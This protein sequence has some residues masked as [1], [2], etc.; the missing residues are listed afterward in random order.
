MTYKIDKVD[1]QRIVSSAKD[2]FFYLSPPLFVSRVEV[3]RGEL[4]SLAMLESVLMFL[5]S[6]GLLTQLVN[7]D[8]TLD[9][10]DNDMSELEERK[11]VK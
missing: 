9:Y 11:P 6:K 4:P 3:E 1:L 7:V 5:N 10:E 8:Y 2:K